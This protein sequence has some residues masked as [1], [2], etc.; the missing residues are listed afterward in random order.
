MIINNENK[1]NAYKNFENNN[2]YHDEQTP[3]SNYSKIF[4]PKKIGFNI[5][6]NLNKDFS[7]ETNHFIKMQTKKKNSL[8]I[9][10][11]LKNKGM[12][13]RVIR[14][15]SYNTENPKKHKISSFAENIK[16]NIII[17]KKKDKS[18]LKKTKSYGQNHYLNFKNE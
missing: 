14:T 4:H 2:L 17:G 7:K 5:I 18:L 9:S 1:I 15:K 16:G 10:S 11:T 6:H 13:I 8:K 12:N 3:K